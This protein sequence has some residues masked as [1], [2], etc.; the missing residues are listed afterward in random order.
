[1]AGLDAAPSAPSAP[2]A[3]PAPA[4]DAP[5][6]T[7]SVVSLESRIAE[8][9]A[10]LRSRM[11]A[12][13]AEPEAEPVADDVD[14]E[15]QAEGEGEEPAAEDATEAEGEGEVDA[16]VA[17]LEQQVAE[18]KARDD[19]WRSA[20]KQT[21]AQNRI[22]SERIAVLEGLLSEAGVEVDPR[23]EE[24]LD[25]KARLIR[26]E[27]E[28]AAAAKPAEQAPAPEVQAAVTR[29]KGELS[30]AARAHGLAEPELFVAWNAMRDAGRDVSLA[31]VGRLMAAAAKDKAAEPKR[32]AAKKQATASRAAPSPLRGQVS[33]AVPTPDLTTEAGRRR[34]LEAIGLIK[35]G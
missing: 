14:L 7:A 20:A 30:E 12:Q 34:H 15:G 17:E 13:P 3:S 33:G 27:L 11:E 10:A 28:Q 25:L 22:L 8:K 35:K 31:D 16:K 26:A 5:A 1:M 4:G 6:S 24:N 21:L 29:L 32:A 19:Q 18:A 23:I 2:S 9:K